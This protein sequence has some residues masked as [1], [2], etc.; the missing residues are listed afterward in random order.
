MNQKPNKSGNMQP[1]I[2][3]GHGEHSG[4]YTYYSYDAD[5]IMDNMN[6]NDLEYINNT[7]HNHLTK[8]K[9]A[10]G[11]MIDLLE[12]NN[13]PNI[14]EFIVNCNIPS[15]YDEIVFVSELEKVKTIYDL[16]YLL[17]RANNNMFGG[18]LE[19]NI[20]FLSDIV[21][22][23]IKIEDDNYYYGAR[24][25]IGFHSTKEDILVVNPNPNNDINRKLNCVNCV[26]ATFARSELN[27][28]VI[29]RPYEKDI[30][31]DGISKMF[32]DIDPLDFDDKKG[33]VT[34]RVL[35]QF[36]SYRNNS[37][38]FLGISIDRNWH[39]MYA[40]IENGEV[41]IYDPQ[42]AR[43]ISISEFEKLR[44]RKCTIIRIDGKRLTKE[45]KKCFV[46]RGK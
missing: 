33:N 16:L 41:R 13:V 18:G 1:Y 7:W 37:K 2:E 30:N 22:G 39:A 32:K 15:G 21:D 9:K 35:K 20:A 44:L 11:L 25:I 40:E 36:N 31:I 28:D 8:N 27:L 38:Y 42:N 5:S 24:K 12:K 23:I 4:E 19:K 34:K 46:R 6:E 14:K 45:G 17:K 3:K 29:S 10:L 26:I 43:E